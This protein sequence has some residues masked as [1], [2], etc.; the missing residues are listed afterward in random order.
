MRPREILLAIFVTLV[1][2]LAGCLQMPGSL[3]DE[4]DENGDPAEQQDGSDAGQDA[5]DP[6]DG[7]SK[8][9]DDGQKDD[10]DDDSGNG[11]DDGENTTEEEC[12]EHDPPKPAHPTNQQVASTDDLRCPGNYVILD[13]G[14]GNTWNAPTWEVGDWWYYEMEALNGQTMNLQCVYQFK[15]TVTDINSTMGVPVYQLKVENF[16][17]DGEPAKDRNGEPTEPRWINRTKESFMQLYN[18]GFISHDLIFPLLDN[19]QWKYRNQA[20]DK[21]RQIVDASLTH[22]PNFVFDGAP[23]ETWRVNLEWAN[24]EKTVWWGVEEQHMLRDEI[25]SG[26]ILAART[27]LID[28]SGA[29]DDDGLIPMPRG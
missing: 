29:E 20:K 28:H 27:D 13:E 15:E 6:G 26:T 7:T 9:T 10:Q 16:D 17:C 4:D 19:K 3:D 1:L 24:I 22:Q 18:D 12:H 11:T 21:D 8:E 14:S 2:V 25:W 23:H 5:Q